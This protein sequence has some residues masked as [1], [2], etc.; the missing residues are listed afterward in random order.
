MDNDKQLCHYLRTLPIFYN[1]NMVRFDGFTVHN[2]EKEKYDRNAP[3]TIREIYETRHGKPMTHPSLLC[4]AHV[5]D[6]IEKYPLEYLYT[7]K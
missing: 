7:N 4:I 5:T 1:G 2:A 6:T 3:T